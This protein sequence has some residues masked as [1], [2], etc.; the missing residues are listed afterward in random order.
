MVVGVAGEEPVSTSAGLMPGYVLHASYLESLL[1]HEVLRDLPIGIQLLITW[2]VLMGLEQ[3]YASAWDT[4]RIGAVWSFFAN[5]FLLVLAVLAN[6]V[7]IH[8]GWYYDFAVLSIGGLMLW[9][10]RAVHLVVHGH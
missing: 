4:G 1:T 2:A 5:A 9:F 3:M 6:L 10:V 8:S 7:L